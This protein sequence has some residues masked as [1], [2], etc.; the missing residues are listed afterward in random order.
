MALTVLFAYSA[1]RVGFES[2]MMRMNFMPDKLKEA[3]NR[4]NKINPAKR[5]GRALYCLNRKNATKKT[6]RSTNPSVRAKGRKETT[7]AAAI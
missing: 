2:D 5:K 6:G 4:L 3:E 1:K 7:M